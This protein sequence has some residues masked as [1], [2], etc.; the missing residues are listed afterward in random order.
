MCKEAPQ[1]ALGRIKVDLQAVNLSQV[2]AEN[3]KVKA[4][5]KY[6]PENCT[7]RNKVA[8][9]VPYR[10]R[11][12]H[13][14]ALLRHIHPFLQRQQVEYGIY[15]V[16]QT[17]SAPF[18][19]GM[20][21][22]IGFM[23][24]T[25]DEAWQCCVF[26]DV[27]MLP[28]DNR[29]LYTCPATPRHMSV[30]IDIRGYKLPYKNYFGGVIALTVDH[31]RQ[32]NGYSNKFWD[33]GGEDDDIYRRIRHHRLEISR[34]RPEI[35]RYTGFKHKPEPRNK[36]RHKILKSGPERYTTDG[37]NSLKYER[38]AM[39]HHPLYTVIDVFLK[40]EET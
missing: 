2:L 40:Q 1:R 37:L 27:D 5:G 9:I 8:I 36:D 24:A 32:V 13:L 35:A 19:R 25:Q 21:T 39:V 30:A 18:N 6:K 31:F 26:H 38:R 15:V 4:G 17:D 10:N 14:A 3:P 12:H 20:V 22:N 34:Y 16:N 29:N 28:E 33:W 7:A 11:A 23:E